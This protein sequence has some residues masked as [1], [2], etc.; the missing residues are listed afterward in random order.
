M[1]S[2]NRKRPLGI[3]LWV[4]LH[5]ALVVAVVFAYPW[6]I[7]RNLF[8]IVPG[9]KISRDIQ[10]AEAIFSKRSALQM[11]LFVGDSSAKNAMAAAE[12][13]GEMLRKSEQVQTVSWTVSDSAFREFSDFV[14]ANRFSLQDP[15][16]LKQEDSS[17][18]E[19]FYQNALT[20]IF[21]SFGMG[22]FSRL[23]EDPTCYR[24]FRKNA[25]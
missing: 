23:D 2:E 1:N 10:N 18:A 7:D 5:V 4:M 12:E 13:I 16:I 17:A 9:S 3:F 25:S 15:S 20:R 8:S 24:R 6:K 11:M 14:F 22:H 21:G 19:M